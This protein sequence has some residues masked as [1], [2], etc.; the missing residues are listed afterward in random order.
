MLTFPELCSIT[1]AWMTESIVACPHTAHYPA[2]N[3]PLFQPVFIDID[4][5]ATLA[6]NSLTHKE[7]IAI[8]LELA[9]N[10]IEFDE[11][12]ELGG[13][14]STSDAAAKGFVRQILAA[15]IAPAVDK[16]TASRKAAFAKALGFN[17]FADYAKVEEQIF[18]GSL[19][20]K[21]LQT[22]L[23]AR[24]ETPDQV[25]GSDVILI[26]SYCRTQG[27]TPFTALD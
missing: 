23:W 9:N 2:F 5:G 6:V 3:N 20:R 27:H 11:H 15:C 13:G 14:G 4:M 19:S 25:N 16:F 22:K 1:T 8:L 10:P 24:F 21:D 26:Q 7:F 12:L 17:S 18:E